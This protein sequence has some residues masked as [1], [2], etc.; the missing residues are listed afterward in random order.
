MKNANVLANLIKIQNA[1][2]SPKVGFIKLMYRQHHLEYY[3]GRLSE[4]QVCLVWLIGTT[5][6]AMQDRCM[7][8]IE[9]R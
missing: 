2:L 5:M 8:T 6:T 1:K 9:Y 7:V 3:I 4:H